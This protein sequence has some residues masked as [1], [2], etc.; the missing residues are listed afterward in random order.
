MVGI[1]A[2]AYDFL[3]SQQSKL[4]EIPKNCQ[5]V[6]T[7]DFPVACRCRKEEVVLAFELF[8]MAL[9]REIGCQYLCFFFVM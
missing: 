7:A 4:A 2:S 8:L 5:L 3:P 9:Y 1:P 6:E